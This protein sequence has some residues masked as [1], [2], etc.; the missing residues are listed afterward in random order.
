MWCLM[1]MR[2]MLLISLNTQ[3]AELLLTEYY[4]EKEP[5]TINCAF[6]A[7]WFGAFFVPFATNSWR[8]S[9]IFVELE[10]PHFFLGLLHG[11]QR[12]RQSCKRLFLWSKRDWTPQSQANASWQRYLKNCYCTFQNSLQILWGYSCAL[13]LPAALKSYII[14]ISVW[15]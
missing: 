13:W 10:E 3:L 2:Q 5:A 6:L 9:S 15:W 11:Y 14:G 8:S 7:C 12:R 1:S 4:G